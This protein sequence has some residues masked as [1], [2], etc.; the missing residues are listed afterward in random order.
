MACYTLLDLPLA[1]LQLILLQLELDDLTGSYEDV[2]SFCF[3]HDHFFQFLTGVPFLTIHL[4]G[5]FTDLLKHSHHLYSE[6]Y[7]SSQR[8]FRVSDMV[9]PSELP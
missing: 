3:A 2:R 1:V 5:L 9:L 8:Y 4:S 6:M 7:D